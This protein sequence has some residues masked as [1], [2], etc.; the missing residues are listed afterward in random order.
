[1]KIKNLDRNLK[2]RLGGELLM[3]ITFWMF[4]PFLTIYFAEE[5]GKNT[6]GLLLVISQIFSVIANLIGGYCADRFGRKKMMVVS[7]IG[8]GISFVLFAV[9]N[10]PS[11]HF[12]FISYFCFVS[13]GVFTSIYWPASQAMIADV[14]EQE[15]RSEVFAIFYTATNI[16]VVI[17]PILGGLFYA[18]HLFLLLMVSGI[19]CFLLGATLHKFL[20]ETVPT[21]MKEEEIDKTWYFFLIENFRDYRIIFRDK[22]F[23]L[24]IV[25]GILL[26]QT[27]MQLDLLLPV[28]INENVPSQPIFSLEDRTLFISGEQVFGMLLSENG[29][30]VVLFTVLMTKFAMKFSERSIF[31]LSSIIYGIA[32][33]LFGQTQWIWGLI[34]IMAIFTL[35][36]LIAVGIQQSFVSKIAPDHLRGQYF[37]AASLRFTVGKTIAPIS[38]PLA[39]LVGYPY[40]FFILAVL[41]I[42]SAFLYWL[43]FKI[44]KK[45]ELQKSA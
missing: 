32:I 22:T 9:S 2:I 37:A 35:A 43:M 6:A 44:N 4:F 12:P 45:Q 29:L 38:I 7:S 23:L 40:T 24:F 28:Y 20:R 15:N 42:A 39:G 1:M 8:Q 17:G 21:H 34:I 16:A 30:L 11:F 13:I 14:V 31:M 36:E 19:I 33:I 18:N 25:A 26:A 27:Y 5:F 10:S 3:N 41:S